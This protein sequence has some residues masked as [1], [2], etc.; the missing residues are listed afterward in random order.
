M[1]E[2]L[3]LIAEAHEVSLLLNAAVPDSVEWL[4]DRFATRVPT[5]RIHVFAA[6]GPVAEFE[7]ANR[8]RVRAAESVR[9]AFVA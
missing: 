2:A 1:A 4:R 3:T 7:T 5:K 8:W 6:P 9:E